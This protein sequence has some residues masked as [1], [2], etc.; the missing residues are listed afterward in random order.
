MELL[1]ELC[2]LM[3]FACSAAIACLLAPRVGATTV[4]LWS[5]ALPESTV[6]FLVGGGLIVLASLVRRLY[7]VGD[8][9][10]PKSIQVV[11][12]MSPP[13][14]ADH[15]APVGS[16]EFSEPAESDYSATVV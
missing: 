1:Q 8:V 5:Y 14:V 3:S 12:W 7:P 2:V 4:V 11:L 9:P 6:L 10:G 15:L 16:H 13:Q